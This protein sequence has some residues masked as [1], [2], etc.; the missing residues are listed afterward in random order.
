MTVTAA[1]AQETVMVET[2]AYALAY[3]DTWEW[4][5]AEDVT[6]LTYEDYVLSI[7]SGPVQMGVPAGEFQRRKLIGAYGLAVDLLVYEGKVKQV[8]YGR[9][10]T[11]DDA[12]TIILDAQAGP[13]V[14][15][16]DIDIPAAIVDEASMI[17]A[18]L[19]LADV[20]PLDVSVMTFFSGETNPLDDWE[21]YF[22]DMQP[23]GFLYP[24]TWTLEETDG[25]V[26]LT[27]DGAQFDI[28]YAP[29]G[30]DEPVADPELFVNS[31]IGIRVPVYGMFQSIDSTAID[32]RDEGPLAVVYRTVSTP[33]NAFALWLIATGDTRL[34][35]DT[36]DEVDRIVSTFKTNRPDAE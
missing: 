29:I 30:E 33:D 7:I 1:R 13:D 17:I 20:D 35:V 4:V 28:A 10:E 27:S 22:N 26:T 23:F 34:D 21:T 18:S 19:T 24:D 16:D 15:Y 2:D 12:Y 3:P 32:P 36:M 6:Q 5:E 25:L 9:L 14:A 8:L 31:N 11:P